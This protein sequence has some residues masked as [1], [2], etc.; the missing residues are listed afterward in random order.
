MAVC[1]W[2]WIL[3]NQKLDDSRGPENPENQ[4]YCL[5]IGVG[6]SKPLLSVWEKAEKCTKKTEGNF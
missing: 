1:M 3:A 4:G 2:M 6:N 5:Q